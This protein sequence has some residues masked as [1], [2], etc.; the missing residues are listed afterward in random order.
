MGVGCSCIRQWPLFCMCQW[1]TC[2]WV[3]SY[4]TSESLPSFFLFVSIWCGSCSQKVLIIW[5]FVKL[6]DCKTTLGQFC[7][8]SFV[9][10][11]LLCWSLCICLVLDY[12]TTLCNF[13][14]LLEKLFLCFDREVRR[15]KIALVASAL[16]HMLLFFHRFWDMHTFV[17]P[18]PILDWWNLSTQFLS[19]LSAMW[20]LPLFL[21]PLVLTPSSSVTT[22]K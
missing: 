9:G 14:L 4:M 3:P 22:D 10:M 21:F 12:F 11:T 17:L 8:A 1:S 15:C 7:V 19:M 5:I 20:F 16:Y 6:Y 2:Q 18:L 13:L